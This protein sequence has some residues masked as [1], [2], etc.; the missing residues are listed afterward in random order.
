VHWDGKRFVITRGV[1]VWDEAQQRYVTE[2]VEGYE[3]DGPWALALTRNPTWVA[4]NYHLYADTGAPASTALAAQDTAAN[5]TVGSKFRLR[6]NV[7]DTNNANTANVG[8]WVLQYNVNG[9]AFTTVGAATAVR[10]AT[11]GDSG[12][13]SDGTALTQDLSAIV[14]SAYQTTWDEADTNNSV[15]SRTWGDTY[16]EYEYCLQLSGVSAG[17]TVTFRMLSPSTSTAVTFTN[18]PTVNAVALALSGTASMS[19]ETAATATGYKHGLGSASV[20]VATDVVVTG[21]KPVSD[22][23]LP[24]VYTALHILVR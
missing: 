9:G 22:I 8:S 11:S 5:V 1:A 12:S 14:G 4:Q 13:F 3:Y 10:Y 20:S 24:P 6:V 21:T 19:A 23:L 7:G 2:S 15:P 18:V 16:T 17:D